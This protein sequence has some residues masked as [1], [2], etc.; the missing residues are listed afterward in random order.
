MKKLNKE[1]IIKMGDRYLNIAPRKSLKSIKTTET[2]LQGLGLNIAE[3]KVREI[4]SS[5]VWSKKHYKKALSDLV[6]DII[7]IKQVKDIKE[8]NRIKKNLAKFV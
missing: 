3:E 8:I 1:T 6:M 4:Y 7:T 2:I 5:S